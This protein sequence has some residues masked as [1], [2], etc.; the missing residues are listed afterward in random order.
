MKIGNTDVNKL[1]LGNIQVD[2]AYLGN[3]Q[4]FSGEWTPSELTLALWLDISD[5]D[6]ITETSNLVSQVDD[7]SGS[8]NHAVQ[9]NSA[10]QP[11]LS[12]DRL[13]YDGTDKYLSLT[14]DITTARTVYMLVSWG[15]GVSAYTVM[16]GHN[17]AA[18][19]H[20][21]VGGEVVSPSFASANVLNGDF[22]QD[23]E[24]LAGV[25]NMVKD[26]SDTIYGFITDGNVSINQISK[27]RTFTDR[28]FKGEIL[29]VIVSESALSVA[30]CE[31]IEGYLAWKWG[32]E[33]SLPSGH[34]YKDSAPTG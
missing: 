27:D 10:N 15:T 6:T 33:S 16:I 20:G 29:E 18:D 9:T 2:K 34:T 4:V 30:N 25:G 7:K 12:T 8:N 3:V 13:V 32:L 22:R 24:A 11:T 31:K 5:S 17:T 14:T 1:Y 19:F 28:N 21:S 23:G 26:T